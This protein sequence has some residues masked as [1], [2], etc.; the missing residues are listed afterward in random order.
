MWHTGTLQEL[1]YSQKWG[2][3]LGPGVHSFWKILTVL[4]NAEVHKSKRWDRRTS[5]FRNKG[6]IL[7][8]SFTFVVCYFYSHFPHHGLYSNAW[9]GP[10]SCWQCC[11]IM[12]K[13]HWSVSHVGLFWD[14]WAATEMMDTGRRVVIAMAE[15]QEVV[16]KELCYGR[17]YGI[18]GLWAE[19][20]AGGRKLFEVI[21]VQR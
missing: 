18:G 10:L 19:K 2:F 3:V 6:S 16:W 5:G 21:H 12:N 20:F 13:V 17:C 1:C 11:T 14:D 8:S 4:C 15:G 7:V 9:A